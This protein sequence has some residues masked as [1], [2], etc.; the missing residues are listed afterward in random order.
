MSIGCNGC[1]N[2]WTGVSAAHCG[3]AGCHET[4]AGVGAFDYHRR[5]G[6]C[7]PPQDCTVEE[8]RGKGQRTVTVAAPLVLASQ[9]WVPPRGD[10]PG[11]FRDRGYRL[12]T[13]AGDEAAA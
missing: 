10:K 2:T 4:F 8:S 9:V 1:T 6:T 12:W 5:G 13:F 7:V 11:A 3:A